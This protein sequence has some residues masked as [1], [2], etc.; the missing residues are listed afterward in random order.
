[1]H[2]LVQ[3][4]IGFQ[5]RSSAVAVGLAGI[6]AESRGICGSRCRWEAVDGVGNVEVKAKKR[7]G[8]IVLK[9]VNFVHV[10]LVG[11]SHAYSDSICRKPQKSGTPGAARAS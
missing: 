9:R 10:Q 5:H 8:A 6:V 1:L 2:H 7:R 11:A 4:R 3:L